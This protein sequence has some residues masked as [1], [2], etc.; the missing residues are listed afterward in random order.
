MFLQ[1]H[2]ER[3][4]GRAMPEQLMLDFEAG[5]GVPAVTRFRT[6]SRAT[7]ASECFDVYW[8]FAAERQRV[9][10]GARARDISDISRSYRNLTR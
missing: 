2:D 5:P 7:R 1:V 10:I 9:F 8:R 3:R 4:Q 6:G